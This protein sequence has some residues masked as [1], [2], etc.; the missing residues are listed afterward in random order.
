M[1]IRKKWRSAEKANIAQ[2][3]GTYYSAPAMR[4][5]PNG[6]AYLGPKAHPTKASDGVM[7]A[8]ARLKAKAEDQDKRLSGAPEPTVT[9]QQ[10]RQDERR[11]DKM[12]ISMK[13]S[14]WHEAKGLP[15]IRS[16]IRRAA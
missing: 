12:P 16:I 11:A 2:K 5:M 4:T 8:A 13:Q 3:T 9:R 7:R 6:S 1:G 10:R 15:K 14:A